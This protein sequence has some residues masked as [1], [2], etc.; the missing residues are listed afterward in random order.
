MSPKKKEAVDSETLE[1]W[2]R[3]HLLALLEKNYESAPFSYLVVEAGLSKSK[4]EQ[5]HDLMNQVW[6]ELQK[7][8]VSM[9]HEEFE[10][11]VYKIVPSKKGDYH[12]AE[13]IVSTLN[14]EGKY[15][16]VFKWMK[17][18]GMNI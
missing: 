12:F 13:S 8:K 11:Q 18:S 6:H 5:I 1:Y 14:Q 9:K 16:G 7:H 10:D 2:I 4:V 3:E 17:K 15:K